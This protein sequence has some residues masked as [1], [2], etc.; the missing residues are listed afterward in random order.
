MSDSRKAFEAWRKTMAEGHSFFDTWQA[1]RRAALEEMEP[2][3]EAAQ[4]V[5]DRWDTPLWKH[6]LATAVI[7][8][9]LRRALAAQTGQEGVK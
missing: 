6:A 4:E 2:L 7:I 3:R 9:R 5:I 8:N 1:A